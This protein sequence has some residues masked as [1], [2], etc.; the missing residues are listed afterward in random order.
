MPA[1]DPKQRRTFPLLG[2]RGHRFAAHMSAFDPK[3]TGLVQVSP[4]AMNHAVAALQ[5]E[6]NNEGSGSH[7]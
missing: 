3:R 5:A 4:Q 2:Q 1:Y 6:A 7:T